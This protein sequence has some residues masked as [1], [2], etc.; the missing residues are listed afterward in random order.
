MHSGYLLSWI[1]CVAKTMKQKEVS[2]QR[3]EEM[4]I[5]DSTHRCFWSE[6]VKAKIKGKE[7]MQKTKGGYGKRDKRKIGKE[8]KMISQNKYTYLAMAP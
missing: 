4:I 5:T 7:R 2:L 3:T 8:G 6:K 1:L